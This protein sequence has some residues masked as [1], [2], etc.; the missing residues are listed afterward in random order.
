MTP[1]INATLEI[2]RCTLD[3]EIDYEASPGSA[4]SFDP[5]WGGDPGEWPSAEILKVTVIGWNVAGEERSRDDHWIW[6][7]LDGIAP[8][9]VLTDPEQ[10]ETLCL[11]DSDAREEESGDYS[12]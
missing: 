1:S 6:N 9:A 5:Y 4:P 8:N 3:V 10:F 12:G 2:G 11:D 7:V